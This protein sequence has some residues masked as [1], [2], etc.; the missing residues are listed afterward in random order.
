M[1]NTLRMLIDDIEKLICRTPGLTAT[2]LARVLFGGDGYNQRVNAECRT[3]VF[4]RRIERRGRGGPGDP[5]TYH[6]TQQTSPISKRNAGRKA[7]RRMAHPPKPALAIG[8]LTGQEAN[9]LPQATSLLRD[10]LAQTGVRLLSDHSMTLAEDLRRGSLDVAF[11]RPEQNPD[12]AYKPF[13]TEP[14][15]ALLPRD[16]RLAKRKAIDPGDLSGETFIGVSEIPRVL[17]GIISDYLKRYRIT[18]TPQLEIDN[19]AMGASLVAATRGVALLPASAKNFLPRSVVSRPLKGET[20][21]IDLVVGYHKAN[22]SP[23]LKMFLSRI[24]DLTTRYT[25]NLIA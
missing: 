18:I 9:C 20:P 6:P 11:L 12:L 8:C 10:E 1:S 7:V 4:A 14:L 25:A 5:F 2:A 3:L 16:H 23:F 17:R 24:D 21:T 19:L 13:V 15:V 22:T